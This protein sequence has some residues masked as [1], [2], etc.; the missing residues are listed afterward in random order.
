MIL[1]ESTYNPLPVILTLEY[2]NITTT[3]LDII[4]SELFKGG[5]VPETAEEFT[6]VYNMLLELLKK[7]YYGKK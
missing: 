7:E 1:N 2:K 5:V 4:Q 6:V 3:T